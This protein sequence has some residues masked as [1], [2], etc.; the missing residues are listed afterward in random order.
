MR[1]E[2][3]LDELVASWT[4]VGQD[5]DLIGNKTGATRLGFALMLKFFELEARFPSAGSDFAEVVVGFVARQVRVVAGEVVDY[6]WDGSASAHRVQIRA[7]FGFRVCTRADELALARWLAGSVCPTDE[8]PA[9]LAEA[10]LQQCRLLRV[11]PPGRVER[12]IGS[13]RKMFEKAFCDRTTTSLDA[14]QVAALESLVN[15][16]SETGLL[17]DLKSDPGQLGLETLL[18]EIAKL[19][20][21]RDLNLPSGLFDDVSPRI[22]E[23][24]RAR[25]T[26]AYRSDLLGSARPVRITLVAALCSTRRTE[27]TDALVDLLLGLVHKINTHADRRVERELIADL[28]RVRGKDQILFR[29]AEVAVEHPDATIREA[30]YPVVDERTLRDLVREARAEERV[31]NDRVRTVLRSSY[32]SYYRR[33]LPA[34]LTAL[35][36]RSNNIAYRP[37]LDAIELLKRYAAMSGKSRYYGPDD[38][39]PIDGVVPRSWRLAVIDDRGRVERIPYEL[40]VLVALRDAIRRREVFIEGA[41]R[42]VTLTMIFPPTSRQRGTCITN[43]CD[44]RPTP[45]LSSTACVNAWSLRSPGSTERSSTIRVAAC[46]S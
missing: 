20:L 37:V 14:A 10:L 30:L 26:R 11:E 46:G 19:K 16:G 6:E 33:M 39:V 43:H 12:I 3:S 36:F 29:V 4:L 24:W 38:T 1:D 35:T 40:C 8:R 9:H 32:S 45:T 15:D 7:A 42:C 25:A 2:L 34:L 23:Q 18:R 31:F 21:V 22:V 28:R 17:A 13:A 5:W 44:N 41:R 27:I